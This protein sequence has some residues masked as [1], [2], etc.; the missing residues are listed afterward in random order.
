MEK[1]SKSWSE[2][3]ESRFE[4]RAKCVRVDSSGSEQRDLGAQVSVPCMLLDAPPAPTRS[5]HNHLQSTALF[6]H[7]HI[8]H[9]YFFGFAYGVQTPPP[10]PSPYCLLH[11]LTNFCKYYYI[12]P[13]MLSASNT[14]G[15]IPLRV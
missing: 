3:G 7:N 14:P 4:K 6:N 10:G 2:I 15:Y 5:F 13:P 8:F 9:S 11:A 1:W 12:I